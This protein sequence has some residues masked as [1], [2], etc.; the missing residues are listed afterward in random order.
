MLVSASINKRERNKTKVDVQTNMRKN[1]KKK[2][3]YQE[4]IE[5]EIHWIPTFVKRVINVY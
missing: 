4:T 1:D 5:R 3:K 2:E